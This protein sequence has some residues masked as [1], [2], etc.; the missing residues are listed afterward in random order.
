MAWKIIFSARSRSDLQKIVDYIARD[1]AV[2]AGRFGSLLITQAE[3][4]ENAPEMGPTLP[5]RRGVRFFP[6]GR[7]LIIYRLDTKRQV[8]RI[9]RFWHSARRKRPA[10]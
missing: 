4:L 9:L 6:V 3:S 1:N 7:Y 2:A 8:V 10:H 5:Q